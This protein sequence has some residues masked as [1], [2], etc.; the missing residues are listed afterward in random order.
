MQA[1]LPYSPN[2]RGDVFQVDR[3]CGPSS[4]LTDRYKLREVG[5][6]LLKP[7]HLAL[8]QRTLAQP[9]PAAPDARPPMPVPLDLDLREDLDGESGNHSQHLCS[10]KTDFYRDTRGE[11]GGNISEPAHPKFSDPPLKKENHLTLDRMDSQEMA[12]ALEGSAPLHVNF[13]S[14]VSRSAL[15]SIPADRITSIS[16]NEREA[17]PLFFDYFKTSLPPNLK[18][19][20]ISIRGANFIMIDNPF[21]GGL[22][23]SLQTLRLQRID[24][25]LPWWGLRNLT[26]FTLNQPKPLPLEELLELFKTSTHLK[27]I[28]LCHNGFTSTNTNVAL[29]ALKYLRKLIIQTSRNNSSELLN[30]LRIPPGASLTIKGIQLRKSSPFEGSLPKDFGNFEN[31]QNISYINSLC[32]YV[33]ID[34]IR[35]QLSGPGGKLRLEGSKGGWVKK[36][37]DGDINVLEFLERFNLRGIQ[38]LVVSVTSIPEI[39]VHL[40]R[41]LHHMQD[42][43][44]LDLNLHN[45]EPFI[46]ALLPNPSNT[47]QILCRN[48]EYFTLFPGTTEGCALEEMTKERMKSHAGLQSVMVLARTGTTDHTAAMAMVNRRISVKSE[49]RFRAVNETSIKWNRTISWK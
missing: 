31:L 1:V 6:K 34:D 8:A 29:V 17:P 19:L 42:L 35:L 7:V 46:S 21:G 39:E 45:S 24:V 14:S 30:H 5:G 37:V 40:P 28:E 15:R 25:N 41:I 2:A 27:I 26:S 43:R 11:V 4:R 9:C 44:T 38:K 22:P 48:L 10:P 3:K 12:V 13:H 32:L 20:D 16:I 49:I 23:Q 33:G 47:R 36:D 18:H